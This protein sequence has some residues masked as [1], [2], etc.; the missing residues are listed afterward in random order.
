[1]QGARVQS[2]VGELR[3]CAALLPPPPKEEMQILSSHLRA[4]S[5]KLEE[6]P[7]NWGLRSPPAPDDSDVDKT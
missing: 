1:M 2:L 6:E 3:S 5:Q 4:L 7:N